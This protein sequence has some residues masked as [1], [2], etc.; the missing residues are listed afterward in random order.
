MTQ[1]HPD[2]ADEQAYVDYAYE[3]LESSRVSAWKLRDLNEASTGGTFQARF[4]RNAFDEAVIKRLTD[5]DL[6]NAALVFGRIDR[7]LADEVAAASAKS[8]GSESSGS[9][10]SFHIGRLAVADEQSNPVV[11]DWRAPVAE[12]FYRATGRESMGLARRRHFIVDGARVL[13]L[14]D[15]MFGEGRLGLGQDDGLTESVD[16]STQGGAPLVGAG[17]LRGYNTLIATMERGRTGALGDIVATIQAE[18]DEII[19]SP[20]HG[21]LVV[22]GGPG[23]GKTVVALHRAAYLL[24]T[25]RFPLE[26]QGVLVIGPNRVF[27]RYI[28][29]VLPS[30]GEAGVALAVLSD[31]VPDVRFG[32]LDSREAARVKG[33]VRMLRLIDRAIRHRERPLR[34]DLVMPFRSGYLR[35]RVEET[36]RI[37]TAA[38]RRYRRHNAG[39]RYVEN[40]IWSAMAATWRGPDITEADVRSAMSAER[41]VREALDRIWPV[42]TPAELLHDL[43]GS[44]ALLRLAAEGVVSSEQAESLYR[45]RSSDITEVRWSSADA[46]LLDAARETLGPRPARRGRTED[47]EEIRT[48][49]HIVIDEVQDLTPMQLE[50]ATRRSLSGSMTVVGD[51]AQATGP[52][53]PN[54]W[55][56]VLAHLPDRREPR[57]AGLS[58]GYRIPAQILEVAIPVMEA[59]TPGLRVPRSVRVGDS[60]PRFVSVNDVEPGKDVAPGTMTSSGDQMVDLLKVAARE[61]RAM[62]DDLAGGSVAAVVP[63]SLSEA[64]SAALDE[65][66]VAHGRVGVSGLDNPITVVP[67]SL[68]KGLELDGVVV[69][70]PS[71][72]VSED[73]HGMR[74]LYVA[75]TRS[76]QRLTVVYAAAL[77]QPLEMFGR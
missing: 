29:R 41:E 10:E 73:P 37:V 31:L 12:P 68:V 76:T 7:I 50:M 42:L 45:E 34:K 5:L 77:P 65:A 44:R 69:L 30:L 39:R 13:G 51:I 4:E 56:E 16:S 33:D 75:L 9:I 2:L 57:V 35:L 19:R 28:E 6:G 22:Q 61:L 40:E 17:G 71:L 54:D 55:S 66:G 58:V 74:A 48:Y 36:R 53:A 52:L 60:A 70:E 67:I 20:Q 3:C 25:H 62:S 32:A 18:Q 21:V 47:S 72:I 27:L 63:D 49:G 26:D 59:A 43:F 1:Q 15:E 64:F 46:A 14:E 23:T 38:R 11:V 8:S 24:Y